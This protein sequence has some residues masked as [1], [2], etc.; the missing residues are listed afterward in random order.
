MVHVFCEHPSPVDE[1]ACNPKPKSVG[2]TGRYPF[3]AGHNDLAND[4]TDVGPGKRVPSQC[5]MT[6]VRNQAQ[7]VVACDFF[8]V[9]TASFRVLYVFVLLEVGTRR[10][11]HFNVTAHPTATWTLQQFREVM[12]DEQSYRFVLH[13]RD[14]IYSSELDSALKAMDLEILKTPFQAPQ[15]NAFCERLIGTI[16]RECLDFLTRSTRGTCGAFS[17][18]GSHTTIGAGHMRVSDQASPTYGPASSRPDCADTAFRLV[19]KLWPRRSWWTPSRIQFGKTCGLTALMRNAVEKI[20]WHG[21]LTYVQPRIRLGRSFARR[22]QTYLCYGVRVRGNIGSE[23]R[24]FLVGVGESAHAKHQFQVGDTVSGEAFPVAD[25]RL[26]TVEFY[27][28]S[29]LQDTVR[30]VA[31]ETPP[32][33]WR[34]VPP[35]L[36]AS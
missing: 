27:K 7:A 9:V 4:T 34:C 6:F 23:V 11:A 26:E 15:A 1:S 24:E 33:P 21:V 20:P 10:I 32:P 25:P 14:R 12:M 28:V 2:Q 29:N 19:T 3:N 22:T 17:R 13:D 31:E 8:I 35:P 30:E 16:R 36:A 5:W 18:S